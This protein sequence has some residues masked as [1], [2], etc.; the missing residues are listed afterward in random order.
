MEYKNICFGIQ[1][2][3]LGKNNSAAQQ[4]TRPNVL[5]EKSHKQKPHKST[6]FDLWPNA[7][8]ANKQQGTL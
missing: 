1:N 3:M 4:Q 2:G 8:Q 6:K 5:Q 7:I